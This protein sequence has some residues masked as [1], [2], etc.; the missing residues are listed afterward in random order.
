M[1]ER[2][3]YVIGLGTSSEGGMRLL[4]WKKYG[5]SVLVWEKRRRDGEDA[6]FSGE[7]C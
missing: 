1:Y 2:C 4:F 5:L 6:M 3:V 7:G